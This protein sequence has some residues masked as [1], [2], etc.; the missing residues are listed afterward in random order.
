VSGFLTDEWEF[1]LWASHLRS[2]WFASGQI[3]ARA[4]RAGLIERFGAIDNSEGGRTR[5]TAVNGDL[6]W[7][8][9]EN[10]LL[11]VHVYGQYYAL[12]LFS[13]FTFFLN[14]PDNGDSIQQIDRRFVG[15]VDAQYPHRLTPF[16]FPITVAGGAQ[17]R[18]DRPRVILGR[19]V[20]RHELGRTEDVDILEV[21]YSPYVKVDLQPLPWLRLVT[22]A[23]GDV[24]TFDVSDNLNGQGGRLDGNATRARAPT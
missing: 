7:R 17:I 23:R 15:G 9:S 12:N 2:A 20:D 13:N 10:Q 5:R 16:G 24:F 4:V 6:R 1:S 19:E 21:S 22:G 18:L 14:D 8:P 11:S 3:P